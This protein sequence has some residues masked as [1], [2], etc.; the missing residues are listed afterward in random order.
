MQQ[1]NALRRLEIILDEAVTN[2]D[3][4]Q[5]SGPI[6]LKAMKLSNQPSKVVDFYELLNRAEEETKKLKNLPKIDRYLET[7]EELH[8]VFILNHIWVT[9]W[10][11]FAGHIKTRGVLIALDALANYF[12]S[13]NPTVLLEQDF[14]EKLSHEFE[15]LIKNILNSRIF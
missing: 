13:Q 6:I 7:I 9:K 14:L 8:K 10:S 2:G 5:A 3:G 4:N 15:S 11:T 12:H 1:S